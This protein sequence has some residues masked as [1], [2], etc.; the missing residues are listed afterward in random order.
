M[1]EQISIF[2][3][4]NSISKTSDWSLSVNC[5]S[6]NCLVGQ[7]VFMAAVLPKFRFCSTGFILIRFLCRY[8]SRNFAVFHSSG[9]VKNAS[10]A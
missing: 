1:S 9:L 7:M 2:L 5:S 6:L 4:A 8:L 10:L 3:P